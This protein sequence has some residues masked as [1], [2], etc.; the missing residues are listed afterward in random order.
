[1]SP[2]D[3]AVQIL[4]WLDLPLEARPE[5]IVSYFPDVDHAGHAGGPD[6]VLVEDAL[7]RVNDM[8]GQLLRG[9][10]ERNLTGVVN[11][12]VVSDHGEQ[13]SELFVASQC[14]G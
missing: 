12:I 3:K 8:I 7:K 1:M 10:Q 6:S 11:L 4:S 2:S 14:D 9:L 5:L 13:R